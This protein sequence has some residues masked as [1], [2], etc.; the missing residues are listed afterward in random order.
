MVLAEYLRIPSATGITSPKADTISSRTSGKSAPIFRVSGPRTKGIWYLLWLSE[1]PN[2]HSVC[3]V[4]NT[5]FLIIK[6]LS[7]FWIPYLLDGFFKRELVI[8]G[9]SKFVNELGPGDNQMP[10]GELWDPE[11]TAF[12]LKHRRVR[13]SAHEKLLLNV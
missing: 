9:F 11:S 12:I 13:D 10:F 1:R 7:W 6:T 4:Y 2:V 8:W 5:A 3:K